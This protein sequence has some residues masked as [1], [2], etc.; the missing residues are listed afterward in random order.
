[1]RLGA[2]WAYIRTLYPHSVKA[3]ETTKQSRMHGKEKRPK[4]AEKGACSP[5]RN[6]QEQTASTCSHK[7]DSSNDTRSQTRTRSL[8]AWRRA[9]TCVATGSSASGAGAAGRRAPR[10]TRWLLRCSCRLDRL[11]CVVGVSHSAVNINV[12]CVH[13]CVHVSCVVR[14]R[15]T[16]GA[17]GAAAA[18]RGEDVGDAT[19]LPARGEGLGDARFAPRAA[20]RPSDKRKELVERACGRAEGGTKQGGSC[21]CVCCVVVGAGQMQKLGAAAL[22]S[23]QRY[24]DAEHRA[25]SRW[26]KHHECLHG[27]RVHK[28][29]QYRTHSTE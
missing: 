2:G 28:S 14:R 4:G 12:G 5:T 26:R 27:S 9:C 20:S 18:F 25:Q 24:A 21:V 13:A 7:S 1:M 15:Q 16:C 10:R 17:E 23:P 19:S 22:Y 6:V 3:P 8:A 11:G 29:T